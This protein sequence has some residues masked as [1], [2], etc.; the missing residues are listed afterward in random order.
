MVT[1]PIADYLTRIRNANSAGHRVVEIPARN[2]A[3]NCIGPKRDD[4]VA[5]PQKKNIATTEATEANLFATTAL[6]SPNVTVFRLV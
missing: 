3:G 6:S 2:G 5:S 1:D 4:P